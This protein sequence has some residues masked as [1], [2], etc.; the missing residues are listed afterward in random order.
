VLIEQSLKLHQ[1]EDIPKY[2]LLLVSIQII[3]SIKAKNTLKN[4]V[5]TNLNELNLYKEETK[6]SEIIDFDQMCSSCGRAFEDQYKGKIAEKIKEL[7]D[8]DYKIHPI[9]QK[10]EMIHQQ[11][12]LC[13]VLESFAKQGLH[14]RDLIAILK[15]RTK[16]NMTV[17]TSFL[18]T[19]QNF[20]SST[21]KTEIDTLTNLLS[22]LRK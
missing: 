8:I 20:E 15:D 18:D 12:L 9:L 10:V 16:L 22:A 5:N 19:I 21:Y 3:R 1:H 13:N 11:H 6:M 14:K 17:I 2:L 7:E 4:A